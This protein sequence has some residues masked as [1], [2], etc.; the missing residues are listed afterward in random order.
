MSSCAPRRSGMPPRSRRPRCDR[1]GTRFEESP[2]LGGI[3]GRGQLRRDSHAT[4]IA[5][6]ERGTIPRDRLR[7]RR[8]V[9]RPEPD[10]PRRL[11]RRSAIRRRA[12][13]DERN[14][15]A[16]R[17]FQDARFGLFV[18]WGVYSLLAKGE[19]VMDKDKLPI[20]EYA[21]LP[22]RFNPSSFDADA[23]VKLAKD[24]GGAT[25]PSR[26]STTTASACS[27]AS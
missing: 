12:S 6:A 17:W 16:R 18:H 26:A 24:A 27:T 23:W 10:C 13:A 1:H 5:V 2:P 11:S 9:R 20:R 4:I 8:A 14:A 7:D 22:P 25:S 19:W 15:A 3:H 21:K